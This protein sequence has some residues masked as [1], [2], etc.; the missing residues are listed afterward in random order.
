MT[1]DCDI[2]DVRKIME[3]DNRIGS[4]FLQCSLGFGGSCF[5]KDIKSLVYILYSNKI[6]ESALYW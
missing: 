1:P 5:D 6:V 2:A 3:S 4:K